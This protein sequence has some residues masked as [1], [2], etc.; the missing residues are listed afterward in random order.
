[1]NHSQE[2]QKFKKWSPAEM[3]QIE[4][5]RRDVI[6]RDKNAINFNITGEKNY[7]KKYPITKIKK[8]FYNDILSY[9][10]FLEESVK[11]SIA[12]KTLN[13][14]PM[15]RRMKEVIVNS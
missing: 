6:F 4:K 15:T 11:A 3:F 9:D 7:E 14:A 13:L 5:A 2:Y 10:N 12:D 1:M 8:V